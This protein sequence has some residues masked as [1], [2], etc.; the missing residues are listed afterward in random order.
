MAVTLTTESGNKSTSIIVEHDYENECVYV[1]RAYLS[2]HKVVK[3]LNEPS[4]DTWEE[5]TL[6]GGES[7]NL[8][9]KTSRGTYLMVD[10]D[11]LE[12]V[13]WQ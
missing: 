2:A 1:R 6:I 9:M 11:T 5:Y 12:L 13:M 4:D 10:K 7:N 3:H 8:L